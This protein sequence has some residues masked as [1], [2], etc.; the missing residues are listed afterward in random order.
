MLGM[1][2]VIATVIGTAILCEPTQLCTEIVW[3]RTEV[4]YTYSQ[5]KLNMYT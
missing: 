4:I 2:D 3:A 5:A 1:L